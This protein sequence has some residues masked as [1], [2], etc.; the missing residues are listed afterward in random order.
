MEK[1]YKL[2]PAALQFFSDKYHT[3]IN[4]LSWW[5]NLTVAENLLDEVDKC[6]LYYGHIARKSENTTITTCRGW[7]S[8][9]D[10]GLARFDFSLYIRDI[11]YKSYNNFKTRELMDKIQETVNKHISVLTK[12]KK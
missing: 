11:D 8:T 7:D 10:N 1:K 9:K 12:R 5:K 6:Y 3:E 2:K 4:T